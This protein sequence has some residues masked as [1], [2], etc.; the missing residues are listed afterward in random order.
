MITVCK[1]AE[2]RIDPCFG[3]RKAHVERQQNDWETWSDSP[4][5][6]PYVIT[7]NAL[8][9]LAQALALW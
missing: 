4:G 6:C 8:C 7:K 9:V 1:Q 5:I 2:Y 3:S